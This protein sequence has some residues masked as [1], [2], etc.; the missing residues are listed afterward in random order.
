MTPIFN[1]KK[2]FTDIDLAN[3]TLE[4]LKSTESNSV[5]TIVPIDLNQG[6]P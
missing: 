4:E 2:A 3:L 5:F 6:E 1:I